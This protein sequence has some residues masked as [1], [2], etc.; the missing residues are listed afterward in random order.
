[1]TT[2]LRNHGDGS[3]PRRFDVIGSTTLGVLW[4]GV[5]AVS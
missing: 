1:M 4:A 3:D 2:H 5:A